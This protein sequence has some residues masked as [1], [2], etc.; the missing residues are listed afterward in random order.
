MRIPPSAAIRIVISEQVSPRE[1]ADSAAS[2]IC[3]AC[4]TNLLTAYISQ[5][6]AGISGLSQNP[7]LPVV[8]NVVLHQSEKHIGIG[9][10]L[11]RH[12][13]LQAFLGK[14]AHRII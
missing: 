11:P 9:K 14:F 2:M 6:P 4:S 1:V 10:L 3:C 8:I 13:F 7:E 12:Q 5:P